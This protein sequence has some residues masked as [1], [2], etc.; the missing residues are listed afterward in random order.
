MTA[1][2]F[3]LIIGAFAQDN[4]LITYQYNQKLLDLSEVDE[5]MVK[6]HP[7]GLDVGKKLVLIHSR[8]TKVQPPTPVSPVEQTIV[9]KQEIYYSI[10][11][12][13][14]Y[15]VKATK[16]NSLEN[17]DSAKADFNYCLNLALM[18]SSKN[19]S[20]LEAKLR[21]AKKPDEI[22]KVYKSVVLQ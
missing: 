4:D 8:Y 1:I 3:L 15:Y 10:K 11:K 21:N 16:K 22:V 7:F 13:N 18:I 6:E 5:D 17:V 19:T 14:K 20:A 2:F 9:Y 12:L